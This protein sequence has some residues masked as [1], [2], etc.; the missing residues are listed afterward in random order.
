[1]IAEGIHDTGRRFLTPDYFQRRP[2]PVKMDAEIWWDLLEI[3]S[4]MPEK[5]WDF[6]ERN[7]QS[8]KPEMMD[9]SMVRPEHRSFQ[10]F[11]L[12]M[13]DDIGTLERAGAWFDDAFSKGTTLMGFG[14]RVYKVR[15]PRAD[16]QNIV[17][18]LPQTAGRLLLPSRSRDAI[19]ALRRHKLGWRV[20]TNVEYYTALLLEVPKCHA[21]PS[22]R[23]GRLRGR[24]GARTSSSRRRVAV[25]SS[26]VELRWAAPLLRFNSDER[27]SRADRSFGAVTRR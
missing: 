2:N 10:I 21:A 8:H 15:D 9:L 1:M 17:A 13:F 5:C 27:P 23:C 14:H 4:D 22:P 24:A 6:Y 3:S 20:D 26:T 11:D 18:T 12:D 7:F 16:W 19:A 25:S